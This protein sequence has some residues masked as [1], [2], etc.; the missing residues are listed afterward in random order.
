MAAGV[1]LLVLLWQAVQL[2]DERMCLDDLPVAS[3]LLWQV[4]QGVAATV[5]SP[6]F[7]FSAG[8][9]Q[10]VVTWQFSQVVEV[11]TWWPEMLSLP[12]A[13]VPLWQVKQAALVVA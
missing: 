9:N 8:R 6:W 10:P 1:Q 12:V 2:D 13:I 3:V 4:K 7:I 5:A 11:G